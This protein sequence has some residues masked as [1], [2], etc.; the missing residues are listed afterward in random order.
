MG[1][2]PVREL[3]RVALVPLED[4]HVAGLH[5]IASNR[6]VSQHWETRGEP[7]TI[8]QFTSLIFEHFGYQ[9]TVTSGG[10]PIG[11]CCLADPSSVDS[12]ATVSLYVDAPFWGRG[13]AIEA[14]VGYVDLVFAVTRLEKLYFPMHEAVVDRTPGLRRYL[15]IE[16]RLKGHVRIGASCGDLV[17]A[18]ITRAQFGAHAR[19]STLVRRVLRAPAGAGS[20]E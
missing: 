20:P 17:I 10:E 4:H 9:V 13:H 14:L 15:D 2:I 7:V 6:N 3:R 8:E 19:S 1:A 11:L 18:S 5:R 16:G 12:H